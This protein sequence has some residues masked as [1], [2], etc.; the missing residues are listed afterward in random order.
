MRN[1]DTRFF[2][3]LSE[4]FSRDFD[5]VFQGCIGALDGMAVKIQRPTISELLRNPGQYFCRKGYYALNLQAICNQDKKI[6]WLLSKYVGGCHDSRAFRE[7]GLYKILKEKSKFFEENQYFI[8]GDSAYLPEPFLLIPY[9]DAPPGSA[10]DSYNFWHSNSRIR[11]ECTFGE[12]VM[13]WGLFWRSIIFS[14]YKTGGIINAAAKL[15]NFIIDERL[16][17]DD[18][19]N[20]DSDDAIFQSF[21]NKT[22]KYLDLP[23]SQLV[24]IKN[25]EFPHAIVTDNNEPHPGGRPFALAREKSF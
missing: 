19:L 16:E 7:T 25:R 15:H 12:F 14:E 10:E 18:A 17:Q 2:N 22:V 24:E 21:S 8:A 13:R 20:P 11:I 3:E 5:G 6:L 1:E 4:S 9:E 23:Q